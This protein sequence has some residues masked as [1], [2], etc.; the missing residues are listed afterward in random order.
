MQ[1]LKDHWLAV[2]DVEMVK[3]SPEEV[4]EREVSS[5][6]GRIPVQ[7][8]VGEQWE[9]YGR[10]P[11][12]LAKLLFFGIIAYGVLWSIGAIG[13]VAF[14][15]FLSLLL[16]YLLDPTVDSLE[17]RGL[18]R[19]LSISLILLVGLG[20]VTL[21]SVFLYPTLTTQVSK[22]MEHVPRLLTTLQEDLL[23]WL[24]SQFDFNLPPTLSVAFDR[25][26]EQISN[27]L[28][29]ALQQ[30]GQWGTNLLTRTGVLVSS[31][32]NLV[33]IPIFTFYFLRDFDT[34]RLS[35]VRYIPAKNRDT[36]ID[37]LK[38]MDVAVGQWFRG[39]LQVSGILAVLYAIGLA[40]VFGIFGLDVQSGIVIGLLTGFLNVVP[41]FG[42]A[43]GSVLAVLVA[44]IDWSGWGPLIGVLIV[45]GVIQLLESYLITPK[46]VGDKVGLK[47]VTVIIVLLIGGHIAGL[48]GVLLA[49]P[50]AGAFK[51]IL[52]DLVA[53]YEKNSFYTGVP[54][55]PAMHVVHVAES[56]VEQSARA[57]DAPVEEVSLI[58]AS[59]QVVAG[60][61]DGEV[62]SAVEPGDKKEGSEE[63]TEESADTEQVV[64]GDDAGKVP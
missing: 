11:Y 23:P 20:F 6:G 31:I 39:Q 29:G 18:S 16:A 41:Y 61:A 4:S 34:G 17:K 51:V 1:W 36:V 8:S 54:V 19:T 53:L 59:A 27:A 10:Y 42:F 5:A 30:A 45:Y 50:F 62:E 12:L 43:I 49:I 28:P 57:E 3:K 46:I 33:M 32:L 52:P 40:I 44:V 37:R 14:P 2:E 35:L 26:G 15:L 58:Q 47:P 64:P 25:Y 24:E 21:F 7:M 48:L 9:R 56:N 13:S 55:V 60:E 63:S 22:I 38:L